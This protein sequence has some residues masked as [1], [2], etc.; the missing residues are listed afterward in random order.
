MPA[1]EIRALLT[2]DGAR[3]RLGRCWPGWIPSVVVKA[4]R[5]IT[6]QSW[7]RAVLA[8]SF[9]GAPLWRLGK[10]M[11]WFGLNIPLMVVLVCC[12]AGIPLWDVLT[13]RGAEFRAKHAEVAARAVAV[14]VL[15]QPAPAPAAA[16]GA[17]GPVGAG[18]AERAGKGKPGFALGRL[19]GA[20]AYR[21]GFL[22]GGTPDTGAP[23]RRKPGSSPAGRRVQSASPARP[24]TAWSWSRS[25]P[26]YTFLASGRRR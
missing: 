3:G 8:C 22:H 21:S 16:S 9:P 4:S 12:W 17:G 2:A 19:S 24:A 25:N 13:R 11:N 20:S 23:S 15:V 14:P 6:P 7:F 1:A 10:M 26:Y 5:S 18:V